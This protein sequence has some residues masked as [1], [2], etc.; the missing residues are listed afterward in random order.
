MVSGILEVD[1][2]GTDAEASDND[3]ILGLLQNP[4][5]E[6]SLRTNTDDMNV[7]IFTRDQ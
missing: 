2:V 4:L 5:R 3:E 1:L 6:L 7:T